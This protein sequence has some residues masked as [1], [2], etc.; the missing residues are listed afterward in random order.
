VYGKTRP[1][2][3]SVV[4]FRGGVA[5]P[6]VTPAGE[7][8]AVHSVEDKREEAARRARRLRLASYYRLRRGRIG[9][10]ICLYLFGL[11]NGLARRALSSAAP[12]LVELGL[13]KKERLD[14]LFS[15]GYGAFALGKFLVAPVMLALGPKRAAMFQIAVI[16]AASAAFCIW[17]GND[18]V[19]FYAF[20]LL[21]LFS[22]MATSTTL[23]FVGT[24]FGRQYYGR[25]W[26]TL[27][28]SF[29][30]G[31]LVASYAWQPRLFS[32]PDASGLPYYLPFGAC[33]V[34]GALLLVLCALL[35]QERPTVAPATLSDARQ[36]E[37]DQGARQEQ[38]GPP[39]VGS[40][41]E[42]SEPSRTAEPA[43]WSGGAPDL[44]LL[45]ASLATSLIRVANPLLWTRPSFA[46]GAAM[47]SS[48]NPYATRQRRRLRLR[49]LF[50]RFVRRWV[51]WCMCLVYLAFTPIIDYGAH[52][53]KYLTEMAGADVA[54][55]VAPAAA[56]AAAAALPRFLGGS[57]AL[58]G[59]PLFQA[60][61]RGI[62]CLASSACESRYRSYVLAYV[63]ALLVGSFAYDA[64]SQLD[65]AL[66]IA[67]LYLLNV[68][69]WAA[70]ALAEPDAPRVGQPPVDLG[71]A[72]FS[73]SSTLSNAAAGKLRKALGALLGA[74][75]GAANDAA[76]AASAA[77]G[78]AAARPEPFLRLSTAAKTALAAAAGATIALPTSLP[79]AFFALDFGK[80]GA[81]VLSSF[82]SAVGLISSM[83]FFRLFPRVLASRGWFGVHAVLALL[84][85]V[86][87][88]AMSAIMFADNAKF[89]RGYIISS[90]L[91][92]ETVVTLHACPSRACGA[93]PMWRPGAN[94]PWAVGSGLH[95]FWSLRADTRTCHRCGASALVE[96]KVR[97]L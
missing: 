94:R 86:A 57:A 19:Q 2:A 14:E 6:I 53:T 91:L 39:R 60:P 34:G 4:R 36:R 58:S 87:A 50:R 12:S 92:N 67:I 62:V 29:Q 84:G 22:A 56:S 75:R 7:V 3:L 93:Y 90:S 35:L 81:A 40:L 47:V 52:V 45:A 68:A 18:S 11:L 41:E 33:A 54:P 79:T 25:V 31:Y 21:R 28:S 8:A 17:P 16:S 23:P 51:F 95:P 59:V 76:A 55:A 20:A 70:L 42:E 48:G 26:G 78:V 30:T 97:L 82:L 24:W 37:C 74:R 13:A 43:G 1:P 38:Q 32:Q 77:A 72:A 10:F 9:V 44:A 80:E 65:K 63:A 69:C 15:M 85:L 46:A 64:I 61:R 5:P 66:M 73:I 96:C 71:T 88:A 27:A 83:L 89:S 49:P